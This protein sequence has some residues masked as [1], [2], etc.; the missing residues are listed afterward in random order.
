M[1]IGIGLILEAFGLQKLLAYDF[2]ELVQVYYIES[3]S[4]TIHLSYLQKSN[5]I[6]RD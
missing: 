2:S 4:K 5:K 3:Y 6:D 1:K